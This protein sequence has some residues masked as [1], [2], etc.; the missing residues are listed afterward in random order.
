MEAGI[1]LSFGGGLLTC[2][3]LTLMFVGT[4]HR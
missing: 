3:G 4:L 2:I 1:A